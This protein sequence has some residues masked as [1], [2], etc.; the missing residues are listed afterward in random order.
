MPDATASAET[1]DVFVIGGGINGCGI[2]RDASGR[3][4]KVALAEMN[5]LASATSSAS[6][7]LF[8][9]GLRYLEY[10][11]I[12]LVRHALA[13][14]ETLLRAMPHISWPMRFVLPYS[15]DMR[16]EGETSV[17]RILSFA[18]PWMKGRRPAW[19][20]RFGLF[21]YDHL[22]GREIL[23]PTK[24]VDLAGTPEGA[25]LEDRFKK[26]YEY[27]DCWIEDSRL[28]VLN[29]RDA[30][31]RGARIM[32]RTKVEAA[33]RAGDHWQITL[34]DAD[35]GESHVLKARMLVNAGGPWVGDIIHQRVNVK[36]N[37]GVRLVR[38]S[39]IVTRRL[40]D[41]DKCYFFQGTDG[42]IIFAIPYETD[43]TLIGTTD[44]EHHDPNVKPVCTPEEQRYLVDFANGYFKDKI[45]VDDIVWT[46]SGVR[47]LYD[48]GASS[49]TA[50]TRDYT[51][52]VD[53]TDGAPI[54]NIFGGKIT[55]YRKLAEDAMDKIVTFFP[56]TSGHWTAGAPLPGGDFEVSGVETL[57]A[58]LM[59][60]YEFLDTFWARRLVRAYGTECWD[61]LDGAVTEADLG[62]AFGATLTEREVIWLMTREFARTAEDVVWRRN[63][64]GLRL[65]RGEIARLEDWMRTHLQATAA[66]AAQRQGSNS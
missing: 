6:T 55:T 33:V 53:D 42:R 37:E 1:F 12:N 41:H 63:K 3:G 56:G 28:V 11:E 7:K 40:Y 35:S 34:R 8:H 59:S 25:P 27:S 21:L 43:F 5:D 62:E 45:G 36:S 2:A 18:M 19:M 17:S 60:N 58:Q 24:T 16:F 61:V 29:A 31:A 13:E 39:H 57:I 54:L 10:L 65:S 38:G 26:A 47:P 48:D 4:L 9:G 50:A 51:L 20:I 44:A 30:K 22:G 23:P 49:A 32:V 14:R 66:E 15:P 64:L 46:Y 52:K